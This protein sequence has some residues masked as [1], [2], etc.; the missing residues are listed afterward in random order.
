M[1][2]IN[3]IFIGDDFYWKSGTMMSSLY[4]E[5]TW[6]RFD[7]G[8]CSLALQEGKKVIIRPANEEEMKHAQEMLG[9][10]VLKRK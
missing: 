6:K 7:W 4:Q 2:T 8:F 1:E 9:A 5:K 3:I 10:L